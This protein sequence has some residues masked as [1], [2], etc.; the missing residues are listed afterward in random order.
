M[1]AREL[2][3]CM[4]NDLKIAW[5]N[6]QNSTVREEVDASILELKAAQLR[7]G[8]LLKCIKNGEFVIDDETEK[9]SEKCIQQLTLNIK[10][11][12]SKLLK[13]VKKLPSMRLATVNRLLMEKNLSKV[14]IIRKRILG[15]RK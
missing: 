13:M 2:I 10:L 5:I 12:L 3:H 6:F 11:I 14:R 8:L 15:M 9:E 1:K 4:E 7:Y